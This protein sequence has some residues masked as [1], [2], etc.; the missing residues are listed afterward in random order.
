[1]WYKIENRQCCSIKNANNLAGDMMYKY[2]NRNKIILNPNIFVCKILKFQGAPGAA[3]RVNSLWVPSCLEMISWRGEERKPGV[4]SIYIC[5]KYG[6]VVLLSKKTILKHIYHSNIYTYIVTH[7]YIHIYIYIFIYTGI[8]AWIKNP[9]RRT[10]EQNYSSNYQ[11]F[12][13]FH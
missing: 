11:N 10:S 2:S 13:I 6:W 7:I 8:A 3:D 9:S 4:V 5:R 1:M 12:S